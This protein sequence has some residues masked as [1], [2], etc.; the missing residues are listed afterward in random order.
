MFRSAKKHE[1]VPDSMSH[2]TLFE[3]PFPE[4]LH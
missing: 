2:E 4:L 3:Q 1:S